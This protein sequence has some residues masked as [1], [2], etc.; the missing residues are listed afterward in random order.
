MNVLL[1]IKKDTDIVYKTPPSTKEIEAFE[2]ETGD[3]PKLNFM[4]LCLNAKITHCWNSDLAEQFV[5]WF[6]RRHEVK[7][8]EKPL[9][10]KLFT[11]LFHHSEAAIQRM[12]DQGGGG[13]CAACGTR[14]R[15]AQKGKEIAEE[16]H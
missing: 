13:C 4:R 6:M 12:A 8:S 16:G 5:E 11:K 3:G 7:E 1:K 9:L 2:D 10:H 14:K 15:E